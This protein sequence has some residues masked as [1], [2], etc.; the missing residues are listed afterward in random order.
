MQNGTH[1][2]YTN[3][4]AVVG[5]RFALQSSPYIAFCENASYQITYKNGWKMDPYTVLVALRITYILY[6]NEKK[7]T[8][9]GD[10]SKTRNMA[11]NNTKYS[12]KWQC[13]WSWS[14]KTGLTFIRG[15]GQT[16]FSTQAQT[17]ELLKFSLFSWS[18]SFCR[19]LS[20]SLI[21][22]SATWCHPQSWPLLFPWR[23]ESGAILG[24][25][26][27]N[28]SGEERSLRR[29]AQV[30]CCFSNVPQILQTLVWL[31]TTNIWPR[32]NSKI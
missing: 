31:R 11:P 26:I 4:R 27:I 20:L 30:N 19:T 9:Y 7:K 32:E 6:I 23:R 14:D 16:W 2:C 10:I 22:P 18:V 29:T 25:L 17:C 5:T 21:S 24:L 8:L 28:M 13:S 12:I 15:T 3:T 1:Q